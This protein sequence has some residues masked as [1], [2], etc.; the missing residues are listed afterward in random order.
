MSDLLEQ[1]QQATP[2]RPVGMIAHLI[3]GHS[4]WSSRKD[5]GQHTHR[6]SCWRRA[7][8]RIFEKEESC[9]SSSWTKAVAITRQCLS[10]ERELHVEA[11]GQLVQRA[12]YVEMR[13][14]TLT[15]LR[16]KNPFTGKLVYVN[17]A[18]IPMVFLN[19][20]QVNEDLINAAG[21]KYGDKP[22]MP[23][24]NELCNGK[25]LVRFHIALLP[26]LFISF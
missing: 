9:A 11:G 17:A 19:D 14:S 25:Y 3:P 21:D 23:M 6:V 24:L 26:T 5:V 20:F 22:K 4:E 8:P 7:R 18:G 16:M 12:R 13:F 15:L 1:W 2:L 10:V